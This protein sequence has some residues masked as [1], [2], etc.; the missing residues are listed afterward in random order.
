MS[1]RLLETTAQDAQL[2]FALEFERD[3]PLTEQE[4]WNEELG[5]SLP[6]RK[7]VCSSVGLCELR[8]K[9][10]SKRSR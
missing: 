4:W 6:R 8:V 1:A 10:K 5:R 2:L 3:P 7:Q 9:S